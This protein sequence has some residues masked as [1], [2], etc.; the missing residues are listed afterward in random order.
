MDYLEAG[1]LVVYGHEFLFSLLIILSYLAVAPFV[2]KNRFIDCLFAKILSSSPFN[3]LMSIPYFSNSNLLQVKEFLS[4]VDKEK[5]KS[6][7]LSLKK[8]Q[9]EKCTIRFT[10]SPSILPFKTSFG[11]IISQAFECL[12]LNI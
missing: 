9:G 6:N 10:D 1:L 12:F 3:P 8:K 2:S 11:E 4:E 5:P 7:L